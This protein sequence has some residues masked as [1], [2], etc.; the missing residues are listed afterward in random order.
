MRVDGEKLQRNLDETVRRL[1]VDAQ[2]GLVR[3]KVTASLVQD[4]SLESRFVQYGQS[5]AFKCDE[6]VE[7]GGRGEAPSPLRYFL[8]G[9]AFCQGVWYAKGAAV[10]RCLLESLE[11]DVETFLD[12]RGEHRMG[13]VPAYPQW[14]LLEARVGSPSAPDL[15]LAMVDEADARCPLWNLVARAVPVFERIVHNG[16]LLRDTA[17]PAVRIGS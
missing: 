10:V 6:A 11:I 5:F 1:G 17:P 2:D 9:I 3:A 4:V 13:D 8:S 15:V 7:R 16:T 12:M 14:I